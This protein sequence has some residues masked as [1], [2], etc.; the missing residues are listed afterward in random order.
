MLRFAFHFVGVLAL[1]L[2]TQVGGLAWLFALFFRYRIIAFVLAY[3]VLC[4]AALWAA[5]S[6]GRVPLNCFASGPLQV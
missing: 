4:T 6:F 5:P 2:L 3:V 1:T